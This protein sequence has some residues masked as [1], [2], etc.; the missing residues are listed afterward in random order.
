MEVA[1]RGMGETDDP[2]PPTGADDAVTSTDCPKLRA[3][4]L[5]HNLLGSQG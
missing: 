1:Q 2:G 4:G 3:R 5:G